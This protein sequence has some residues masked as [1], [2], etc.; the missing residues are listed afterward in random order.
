MK[1]IFSIAN[2]IM[3]TIIFYWIFKIWGIIFAAMI[4][5]LYNGMSLG[6]QFRKS[7]TISNTSVIGLLGLIGSAIAIYFTGNEKYYY[8]PALAINI[9]TFCF[10]CV[11]SGN[12]KSVL[13]YLAKDFDI[14]A[15]AQIP[16]DNL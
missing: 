3:P 16:Q 12:K 1:K 13:H 11:L 14:K 6:V 2:I 5:V 7:G 10:L 15:I 4:S 9:I 8:I